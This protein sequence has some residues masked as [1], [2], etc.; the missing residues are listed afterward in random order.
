VIT[1][2]ANDITNKEAYATV[3]ELVLIASALDDLL[4]E[5]VVTVL[6]LGQAVLIVPVVAT[7]EA[8][9]KI[10]LLKERANHISQAAWKKSLK[11]F[12]DKVE[13]VFKARNIACHTVPVLNNGNWTLKPIAAAK[14]MK[15]LDLKTKTIPHVSVADL[16]SAITAG[17]AALGEGVNLIE[18]FKRVSAEKARRDMARNKVTK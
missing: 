13:K 7:L 16:R 8:V 12:L 9:R 1:T 10:E 15:K 11:G 18:N 5:V 2:K 14:L 17:E 3:G 4:N 6:D